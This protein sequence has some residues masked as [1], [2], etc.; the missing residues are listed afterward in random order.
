[1]VDMACSVAARGHILLAA[2]EGKPIPSSWAL[3]SG[4]NPTT[5]APA[6]AAGMLQ[7]AGGYKGMGLAMMIEC[8]A[9]GLSATAAS[10]ESVVMKIPPNGAVPRQNAFFFF[11]NPAMVGN[12]ESFFTYMAHWIEHYKESGADEA[13]IPGERGDVQ[14]REGRVNGI[15]YSPVIEAELRQLGDKAGMPLHFSTDGDLFESEARP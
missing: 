6:A 1:V 13:R 4:G 7:P 14:E 3:D 9:A 11:L 2:R 12:E 10:N 15:A 5:D 8:L